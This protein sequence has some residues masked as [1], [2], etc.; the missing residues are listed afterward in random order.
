MEGVEDDG[1]LARGNV[2][3]ATPRAREPTPEESRAWNR[4]VDFYRTFVVRH[5]LGEIVRDKDRLATATRPDLSDAG[6]DPRQREI[7]LL[8]APAYRVVWWPTHRRTNAAWI[9]SMRNLLGEREACLTA[10]AA[11]IL[12][13]NWPTGPVPVHA[14]V[15]AGWYGAYTT[16]DTPRITM[17]TTAIGNQGLPRFRLL[18]EE[19]RFQ[20]VLEAIGLGR[21]AMERAH[22]G[23]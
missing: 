14:A 7:L 1:V 5:R 9:R 13:E 22:E 19:R 15:Y 10:R 12:G 18:H 2:R 6:L 16:R 23:R 8:A 4:A 3:L 17:S 11:D 20:A 21:R